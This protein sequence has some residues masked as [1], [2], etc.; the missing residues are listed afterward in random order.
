MT[1]SGTALMA[2][3][4]TT[5][6]KPVSIQIMITI[7]RKLFSGWVSSQFGGCFHPKKITTWLSR[8]SCGCD[9]SRWS[10]TN[11]QQKL[12]PTNDTAI[13]MKI[14]DLTSACRFIRSTTIAIVKPMRVANTGF[15]MSQAKVL[16]S[17]LCV[18][19]SVNA[20]PKFLNPTYGA[21]AEFAPCKLRK[22]VRKDGITRPTISST[23]AGPTNIA[24]VNGRWKRPVARPAAKKISSTAAKKTAT[25]ATTWPILP[26]DV[27]KVDA[28]T[29]AFGTDTLT[30]IYTSGS[31]ENA[32]AVRKL[33]VAVRASGKRRGPEVTP[34]GPRRP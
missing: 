8:P 34:P 10:Q 3:D 30:P 32:E 18:A 2:A 7:S 13:G 16:S 12:P 9:D 33:S 15:T 17:T 21:C 27:E 25:T 31:G 5:I 20:Q 29:T 28:I 22:A 4:S 1:S 11:F 24:M 14:N 23:R 6:A 26:T 19:G